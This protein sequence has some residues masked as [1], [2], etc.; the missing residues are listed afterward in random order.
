MM[1]SRARVLLRDTAWVAFLNTVV[2]LGLTLFAL[3]SRQEASIAL[4]LR[5]LVINLVYAQSIGL[6]IFALIELPRLTWWWRGEPGAAVL[7][8][9]TTLAIPVGYLTGNL[10]GDLLTGRDVRGLV[11][12]DLWMYA[13][14]LVTVVTSLVAVHLITHRG[15]LAEQR[16]RAETADALAR[17]AQLQ[18]L[19]QQIE[20]HML[21]N[22]LANVHA[23]ID[24]EPERAQ[25][26]LEALSELLHASMQMNVQP[27]VSLQQEFA[28]LRHYLQLMSIRMGGRLA[29]TLSLPGFLEQA[30][31]PPLTLQPLVENAVKHGL[32]PSVA[33]G[34][35]HVTARGEG[36][37]LVIEVVDDGPGLQGSD[38]FGPGRIG[39]GNVRRRLDCAF[40]DRARL[41]VS[42]NPPRGVLAAVTLPLEP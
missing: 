4:H 25:R 20:P 11:K 2:A 27:M 1:A 42:D 30:R 3:A 16:A 41:T 15:R 23:L 5:F 13:V 39:L 36:R 7:S 37:L 24:D 14:G 29:Y 9:V 28:L 18:L 40:G 21:F 8:L 34:T 6:S 26:L 33:G 17:G 10:V 22:T 32:D 19:Q 38:P 12:P 35:I 31:L